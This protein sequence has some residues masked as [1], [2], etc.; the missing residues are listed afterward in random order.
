MD[1][2]FLVIDGS[3][4]LYRAFYALPPLVNSKGVNTG[5]VYGFTNMLLRMLVELSPEWVAVA[6]DKSRKTFRT[7]LYQD[8][9]AQRKPT[10]DELKEQFPLM[11]ELLRAMGINT[12]ELDDYEADD[13]IGTLC[14][15]AGEAGI[16]SLIVTGDRDALQLIDEHTRVLLTKKGISETKLMDKDEL[17]KECLLTPAQITDLKGL[18]GDASDNIPGVPGVGEKT[19]L[20][21]LHE[22]KTVE[23]LLENLPAVKGKLG[24]KLAANQEQAV[25]SKQLATICTRVP[26]AFKPEDFKIKP[27][28]GKLEGFI[29]ELGFRNMKTKLAV[30][31][32]APAVGEKAAVQ[33]GETVECTELAKA[34]KAREFLFSPGEAYIVYSVEG[35]LPRLRL[36]YLEVCKAGTV[37]IFRPES[38]AWPLVL[39]WLADPLFVKTGCDVKALYQTGIEMKNLTGDVAVAAYLT[40][41]GI[42]SY[43]AKGLA[44]YFELTAEGVPDSA[45]VRDLAAVLRERLGEGQ[46][47]SLYHDLEL[48][49]V[50][51]LAFMELAGIQVDKEQLAAMSRELKTKIEELTEKIIDM[52]GEEFNINSPKQLGVILFERLA[53]PFMKKTKTGYST[54]AEV[55]E[56]LSGM[57]PIVDSILEYRLLSKLQSTYLEGMQPLIDNGTG[58]IYSHFQQLVTTTGRL[59][60]TEPNLQ[61]IPVRTELGKRIREF[62]VPGEGYDCLLSFDY[63]QVELRILAHMSG[64]PLFTEAF[65]HDQDIHART[66]SEVFGVPLAE[67]TPMLRTRA[68]AVNFGIVYGISDYG[69]ARDQ[70][71]SRTEAA[72]YINNYFARYTGVKAFMERCIAEARKNGYALTMWG[73]RRYLPDINNSNFNRRSFAE[74][75]AI[76]TPIQ[77]TAADIIKR[78]M[79]DVARVLEENKLKSRLLL[80]VHDEL[81]FEAVEQ[82]APLLTDLVKDAMQNAAQLNVPLVVDVARGQNWAQTKD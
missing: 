32:P 72:T 69:L 47:A 23:S 67:V 68:K 60:S 37:Y 73:R 27:D 77:G 30:L 34:G 44:A 61:N 81:V 46:L 42:N 64:D 49:L 14:A 63:S 25:L 80:Q 70:G 18:M 65:L 12:I 53:L 15:Q 48:P 74:R 28:F 52:A 75:T 71:I 39:A 29:A 82:E 35:K 76:N 50:K 19:A 2:K 17:Y 3:S 40:D 8:Y 24:E 16:N 79:V 36:K 5:A 59:S 6:F 20:K 22:Y 54:D 62:F 45:L 55:L 7:A 21:L 57:H 58:R 26:L 38:E 1:G 9:K 13:I 56:N 78:A 31:Q 43:T 66:A 4:L 10:P 51:V 11:M 33:A 41:T